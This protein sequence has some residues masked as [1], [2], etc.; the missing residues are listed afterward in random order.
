MILKDTLKDLEFGVFCLTFHIVNE[1][2]A[3]K[4]L[5]GS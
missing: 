4:L 3:Y 5:K 1:I 2:R